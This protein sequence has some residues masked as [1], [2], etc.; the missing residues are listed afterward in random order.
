MNKR[1]KFNKKM[2]IIPIGIVGII[3]LLTGIIFFLINKVPSKYYGTYVKYY[4]I[5]GKEEKVTYNITPLSIKVIYEHD[6]DGKKVYEKLPF[7]YYKKGND[8]IIKDK[9]GVFKS[10]LI[11]D[12]D[13][14]FVEPSKDISIAK[15]YGNYYWNIK[16]SK[17]DIYEMKNKSKGIVELVENTMNT[18]ARKMTYESFNKKLNDSNF[19]LYESDEK[20]DETYLYTYEVIY[21]AAGGKLSLYYDRKSKK[22]ERAY[23][24]GS[25]S[26]SLYGGADSDS[27]SVEDIYDSKAMLMSLMYVLGNKDNIELNTYDENSKDYDKSILDLGYRKQVL[28]EYLDLISNKKVNEKN[29]N[30][31]TLSLDNDKYKIEFNNLYFSSEYYLSGIISFNISVK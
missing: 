14:L 9:K 19:Y 28:S 31:Y 16:S 17:A 11:L 29:E 5:D 30:D 15:K 4:Y 21:E 13:R 12:D 1:K 22:F 23:Y 2:I 24:S 27:M 20:T 7:K 18:W 6:I 26:S 8:L 25:F 3:V 10:Y